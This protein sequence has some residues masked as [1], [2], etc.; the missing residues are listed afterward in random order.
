MS[1]RPTRTHRLVK[2]V[3][4][5]AVVAIGVVACNEAPVGPVTLRV[6]IKATMSQAA[7]TA[8]L[9]VDAQAA[10]NGNGSGQ[11]PFQDLDAAVT[12]ANQLGGARILVAPGRYDVNATIRVETPVFIIGSNVM[13][14]DADGL[15]TGVLEPGT[16]STV[17]ATS[18]LGANTLMIVGRANG[19]VLQGVTIANLTFETVVKPAHFLEVTKTQGFAILNNNFRGP[20]PIA[21]STAGSSGHVRG[22]YISGAGCAACIM[23]GNPGSPAVVDVTGNRMV[24]NSNGGVLL[25]GSGTEIDELADELDA[26]VAGNDLS[27]NLFVGKGVLTAFGVRIFVIFRDLTSV[28]NTQ[29]TGHIRAVIK[30]NRMVHNQIGFFID[31][32]FPYRRVG[33]VCDPRTYSGSVD[34]T[35]RGNTLSGSTVAPALVTFTRSTNTLTTTQAALY[36]YLHNSTFTISDP[37]GTLAGFWYDH[38]AVD[39]FLGPCA[40]DAVQEPLANRLMYNGVEVLPGRSP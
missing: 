5:L 2:A 29:S 34:V 4:P 24:G 25:N 28:M 10:P 37:D 18:V 40:N 1:N 21:L 17:V 36:Q 22:N 39:P 7:G 6:P 15:P 3:V 13:Q 8:V 30:D 19:A 12:L 31:A 32:G 11:A 35:L 27:D 23:A 9:H 33:T 14:L 38:P 16:E 26:T 20:A